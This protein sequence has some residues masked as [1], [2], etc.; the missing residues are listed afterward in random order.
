MRP[1]SISTRS[2]QDDAAVADPAVM[3]PADR[4]QPL[5]DIG[6]GRH[7]HAQALRRI[8]MHIAPVGAEQKAPLGLAKLGEIAHHAVAHPVRDSPG[9]RRKLRRQQLQQ[10][11]LARAGFADHRQHLAGIERER[12]VAAGRS[13]G[14]RSCRGLPPTSSGWSLSCALTLSHAPS[15]CAEPRFRCRDGPEPA[16]SRNNRCRSRRTSGCPCRR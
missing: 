3:V 6:A 13:A 4:H 14:R 2:S 15:P 10:R 9:V 5:A 8:L 16:G 7:R 12:N 11:G 1:V